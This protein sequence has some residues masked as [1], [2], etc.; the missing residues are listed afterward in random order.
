MSRCISVSYEEGIVNRDVLSDT[1][2]N[3]AIILFIT[4][5]K[6]LHYKKMNEPNICKN[7]FHYNREQEIDIVRIE[8]DTTNLEADHN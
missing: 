7:L 6:N 2:I 4:A 1:P 3:T 5:K 8:L